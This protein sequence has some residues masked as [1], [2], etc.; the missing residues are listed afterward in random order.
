MPKA[1]ELTIVIKDLKLAMLLREL[2]EEEGT[3]P[4]ALVTSVLSS[5][6]GQALEAGKRAEK[7]KGG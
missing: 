4:D 5:G 6:I 1:E 3:T 2:A 7:G